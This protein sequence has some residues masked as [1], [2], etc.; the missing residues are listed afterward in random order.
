[1]F[2]SFFKQCLKAAITSILFSLP[3][4]FDPQCE[5]L[6]RQENHGEVWMCSLNKECAMQLQYNDIYVFVIGYSCSP[7]QFVFFDAEMLP[8]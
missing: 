6:P 8:F 4:I 2:R 1:M 3:Y 7:N 5:L